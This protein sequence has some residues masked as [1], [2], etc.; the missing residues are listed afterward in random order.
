MLFLHI[1]EIGIVLEFRPRVRINVV[2][3]QTTEHRV[4]RAVVIAD[5]TKK[6]DKKHGT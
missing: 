3:E 1:N 2:R 4:H 5:T 6:E